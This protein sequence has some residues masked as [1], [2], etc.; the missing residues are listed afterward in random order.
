MGRLL[1]E[2][3]ILTDAEI[4]WMAGLFEGEGCIYVLNQKNNYW[5]LKVTMCDKDVVDR[6]YELAGCGNVKEDPPP[7]KENWS[8]SYTWLVGDRQNVRRLLLMFLPF[9]GERRKARA[10]EA[11]EDFRNW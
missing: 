1:Q 11:I 6:F 7:K 8:Q 5:Y 2:V 10:L 9:L 4:A 3:R